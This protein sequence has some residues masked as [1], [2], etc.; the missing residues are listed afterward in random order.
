M[1]AATLAFLVGQLQW[2]QLVQPAAMDAQVGGL[3]IFILAGGAFLLVADQMRDLRWLAWMTWV[4]IALAALFVAGYLAPVVGAF[5]S[6]IYQF[7]A[8][9]NAIFWTWLVALSF[10][11]A[12]FNTD[13]HIRWRLALGGIFIATMY[14]AFGIAYSWKSGWLPPMVAVATI[15]A[16]RSWRLA[17]LMAVIGIVPAI[18]LGSQ[19]IATDQYSYSTRLDAWILV[20]DMVQ[21]NPIFGFGPANYYWYAPLFPIRGYAVEFSSHNQ[22]LDLIAQTGLLGLACFLWFVVEIG[23]LA[24]RLRNQA[25]SG[26]SRAYVYGALGGLAGTLTAGMLADWILPFVYNVG[27]T[28]FRSSVLAWLFLGGLVSIER[29]IQAKAPS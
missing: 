26:F 4:F 18:G 7:R 14:V 27:L 25:P 22:Y 2:F 28:G 1:G 19:A 23:L 9:A 5:T 12:L 16:A 8:T 24:W 13:L 3:A 20:L 17:L 21:A 15:L 6:T 11:Q 29:N 10:S